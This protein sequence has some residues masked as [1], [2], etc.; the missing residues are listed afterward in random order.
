MDK[1]MWHIYSVEYY[2]AL[3]KKKVDAAVFDN[4]DEVGGR[5]AQWNKQVTEARLLHDST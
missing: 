3:N 2:S 1:E 4:M 5:Y